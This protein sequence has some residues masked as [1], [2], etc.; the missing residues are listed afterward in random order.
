MDG[1]VAC[2]QEVQKGAGFSMVNGSSQYFP[3]TALGTLGEQR[4]STSSRSD[5]SG[6]IFRRM[7]LSGGKGT[8]LERMFVANQRLI[9]CNW[10][11]LNCS[12][13]LITV[14]LYIETICTLGSKTASAHTITFFR[15]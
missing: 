3:P 8:T 4:H 12:E 1:S 13:M 10:R 15:T 6:L 9:R 2:T 11:G 14:Y 7:D 5:A